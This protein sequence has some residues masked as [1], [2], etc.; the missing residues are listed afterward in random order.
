MRLLKP[1]GLINPTQFGIDLSLHLPEASL[2][3]AKAALAAAPF[4]TSPRF[5]LLNLS[6]TVPLKFLE[7]DLIAL[8]SRILGNT[9]LP[10]VSS[11]HPP[12]SS[13]PV[14]LFI[15]SPPRAWLTLPRPARSTSPPCWNAPP[16]CSP[17]GGAAHLAAATGAPAVVLWSERAVP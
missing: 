2:R 16:F 9:D 17:R 10:S 13:A 1:L 12:I 4:S 7:E 3:F 8:I 15:V 6:S 11:P 14:S 5:M